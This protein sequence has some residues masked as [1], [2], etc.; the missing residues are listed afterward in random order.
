M[1]DLVLALLWSFLVMAGLAGAV[2]LRRR[3]VAAARVRDLLHVGAGVWVFGW[4][5]WERAWAALAIPWAAVALLAALPLVAPRRPPAARV[6]AAVTSEDERWVGLVLYA[7]SFALFT[8]VALGT[9]LGP[10]PAAAALLA[11]AWGDGL[12]G[13]LGSRLGRRTYRLPWAKRKSWLGSGVVAAGTVAGILA[14]SVWSGWAVGPG[15]LGGAGVAAALAEATAPRGTD[16][17]AVPV[18]VFAWFVAVG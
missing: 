7:L 6:V 5:A 13:A 16:N 9:A 11:L 10:D 17:L 8:T 4:P 2:I 3:G 18:A 14:W 15:A 12:G 1:S